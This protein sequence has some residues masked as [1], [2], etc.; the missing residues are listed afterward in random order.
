MR[1]LRQFKTML[2]EGLQGLW[3]NKAMGLASVISITAVLLIFGI[4]MLLVLN[5]NKIVFDA[6]SKL[7]KVVI[8]LE[9]SVTEAQRKDL[10]KAIKENDKVKSVTFTSKEQALESLKN[11][12]DDEQYILEGL[13]ENPLPTSLTVEVENLE[14]AK[15]VV[16]SVKSFPGIYKVRYFDDVVE[17]MIKISRGVQIGGGIVVAVLLFVAIVL[18]HNTIKIA[19]TNRRREIQIM[20]YVG[21]KNGYIS[22]P[23]L[24]EGMVFGLLGAV[25]ASIIVYYAYGA[26]FEHANLELVKIIGSNF[27]APDLF[28]KDMAIIFGCLGIGIGYLGSTISVTRY[29]DV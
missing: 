20:K 23:F 4:V 21:A 24:F 1:I 19:L 13:D 2:R 9:D 29:L 28:L 18:I 5:V 17:K 14:D 12:L 10:I 16:D 26:L 3:R 27:V 7:D 22:G 11:T 6:G 8:F 15:S 25:F